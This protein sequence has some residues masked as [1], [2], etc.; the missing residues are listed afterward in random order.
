MEGTKRCRF[1][2][3]TIQV[4]AI[5]CR[6]CHIDLRT[7]QPLATAEATSPSPE[8][9]AAAPPTRK[10][11]RSKWLF[12][13]LGLAGIYFFLMSPDSS[14]PERNPGA[15]VAAKVTAF[16]ERRASHCGESRELFRTAL[17]GGVSKRD[18]SRTADQVYPNFTGGKGYQCSNIRHALR[19]L[20][21]PYN[22]DTVSDKEWDNAIQLLLM[23]E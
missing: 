4:D 13:F 14:E 1:C 15:D 16:Q 6:H 3:E 19:T 22:G 7:G 17:D 11:F 20:R 9:A 10:K 12:A 2:A 23:P 21:E 18:F 5:V 8:P